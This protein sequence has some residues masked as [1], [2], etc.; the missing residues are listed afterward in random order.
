MSSRASPN[1]ASTP[2]ANFVPVN[3]AD[4]WLHFVLGVAMIALGVPLARRTA[5]R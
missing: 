2:A 1:P 3:N 4:T 5:D